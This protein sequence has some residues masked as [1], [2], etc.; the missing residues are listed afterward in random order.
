MFF[1]PLHFLLQIL[2]Y[3]SS[4]NLINSILILILRHQK[5]Q[6]QF[7]WLWIHWENLHYSHYFGD[8]GQV[9]FITLELI[10]LTWK[11]FCLTFVMV[12]RSAIWFLIKISFMC[13]A[14]TDIWGGQKWNVFIKNRVFI[15][16]CL[17]FSH[18]QST[19]YLI[20]YNYWDIFSNAQNSF[21]LIDF[22]G[23]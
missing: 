21:D 14:P 12:A 8:S 9:K 5:F 23:F 16:T 20:Q 1:S 22:D 15:L 13:Q 2:I 18:L 19:L 6:M 11:V 3:F 4:F 7:T 10:Y 17:N